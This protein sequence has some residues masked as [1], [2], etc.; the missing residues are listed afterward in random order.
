MFIAYF[1]EQ[2]ITVII[3]IIQREQN[4]ESYLIIMIR[5]LLAKKITMNH[6]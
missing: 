6:C 2:V 3:C 5:I 4:I 1:V